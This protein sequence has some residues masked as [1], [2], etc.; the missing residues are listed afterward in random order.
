MIWPYRYIVIVPA[1][2]KDA[3]N[4]LAGSLDPFQGG[5]DN[6]NVPLSE[7]GEN[8]THWAFNGLATE[9]IRQALA[10]AIDQVPGAMWWRMD[11]TSN[12]LQASYNEEGAINEPFTW[13][14]ALNVLELVT[15]YVV[16][17]ED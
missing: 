16:E 4:Q 9:A 5:G 17:T 3:A 7:D 14:N 11:S 13:D 10:A 15:I 2:A 12:R 1:A 6:F 8:V